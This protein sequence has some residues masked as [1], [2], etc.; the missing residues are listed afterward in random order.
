MGAAVKAAEAGDRIVVRPGLYTE[1]VVVD[2]PLEIVGDGPL[3]DI[4]I[5]ARNASTLVFQASIG[6]VANLTLRQA[7]GEGS[8]SR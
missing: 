5:R 1:A 6:R 2:K 3:A 8:G 4:E 7:G